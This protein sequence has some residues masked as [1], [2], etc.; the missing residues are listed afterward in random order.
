MKNNKYNIPGMS[1]G[2]HGLERESMRT[3]FD[4]KISMSPH[5]G[6]L[7][8]SLTH[9]YI[10][11]DFSESQLEFITNPVRG[12]ED[13][14]E[15]LDHIQAYTNSML[16]DELLWPMSMPPEIPE[17]DNEIPLAYYGKSKCGKEKAIYRRG[18]GLRYGRK[19][20]SISGIHY[21]FSL[22][23]EVLLESLMKRGEKADSS[24]ISQIYFNMIRNYL[25][26]I[27]HIIYLFGASPVV[28]SSFISDSRVELV[29][30]KKSTLYSKYATSLRMSE[31]GY[32]CNEQKKINISFDSLNN[33]LSDICYAIEN[34]NPNYEK[35]SN[36][37][38]NQL[39]PNYLQN[40]NEYYAP[41]RPKRFTGLNER[42]IDNLSKEGV[43]Y[44]EIRSIDIDPACRIG[45]DKFTIGFV[46]VVL[47]DSLINESPPLDD[48]EKDY[49]FENIS[50]VIWNGRKKGLKVFDKGNEKDFR[51]EGKRYCDRLIEIS[52]FMDKEN[53]TDLYTKSLEKQLKKWDSSGLTPSGRQ[54]VNI[55]D[56]N[57]EFVQYGLEIAQRNRLSYESMEL[58]S[59]FIDEM[60]SERVRS[61]TMQE[62]IE[63]GECS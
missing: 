30:F 47:I 44:L 20:Q 27:T 54:L 50:R 26:R 63:K 34:C 24:S 48:N 8:S 2:L 10:Q 35:Y 23:H 32:T 31:I 14:L 4:G 61:I 15:K 56:G 19:M 46:N 39:N 33:Y 52:E 51:D 36:N 40:E 49:I 62:E 41:I 37:P 18:L 38:D 59:D 7:G 22:P 5:P 42:L 6:S 11:T 28:D 45:I 55:L 9:R 21:N 13:S 29:K 25:R 57:K 16:Q 1:K 17:D 43:Q 53:K 3:T 12:I 60:E 58:H